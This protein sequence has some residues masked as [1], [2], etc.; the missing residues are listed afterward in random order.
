MELLTEQGI[1]ATSIERVLQSTGIPKGSFYHYFATKHD[2]TLAVMDAYHHYFCRKLTRY[3]EDESLPPGP[4]CRLRRQRLPGHDPLCVPAGL[5]C[6]QPGSGGGATVPELRL[7]LE[8][9][10]L[11]WEALLARCLRDA[12]TAGSCP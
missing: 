11:D 1:A 4:S 7:R 2:F 12:V 6:G 9:I 3:L 8:Q 10:L 5:P